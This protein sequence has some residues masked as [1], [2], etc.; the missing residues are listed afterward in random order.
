MIGRVLIH[1]HLLYRTILQIITYLLTIRWVIEVNFEN[2][3]ENAVGVILSHEVRFKFVSRCILCDIFRMASSQTEGQWLKFSIY[4]YVR[5]SEMYV[6][7]C[8]LALHHYNSSLLSFFILKGN[9]SNEES[10]KVSHQ[11]KTKNCI[12]FILL[13]S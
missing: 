9:I 13:T 4:N 5:F 11:F 3:E 1:L 6:M 2:N 10:V 7:H 12:S 8:W